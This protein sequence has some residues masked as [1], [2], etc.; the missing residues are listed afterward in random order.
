MF[1]IQIRSPA[2]LGDKTGS[3]FD[4]SWK[5]L[6]DAI[7]MI[8]SG[9]SSELSFEVL[10]RTV[11]SVVLRKQGEQ[12]YERIH[13]AIDRKLRSVKTSSLNVKSTS[14]LDDIL[15]AWNVQRESL[16]VI[17]DV[18]MYLD[19]VYCKESRK[20]FVYDMGIDLFHNII[21]KS[22]KD[23]LYGLIMGQINNA[24]QSIADVDFQQLK[25]LVEMMETV[26]NTS[27]TYFLAEFEPFLL[28]ETQAFY[29]RVAEE[30]EGELFTYPSTVETLLTKE[31]EIDA[32]FL[33]DSVRLKI[34]KE[35]RGAL[36]SENIQFVGM[37]VLPSILDS[38]R[39]TELKLLFELCDNSNDRKKIW[40]HLSQ[41]IT[42]EGLNIN[43]DLTLKKKSQVAVRW[44]AEVI[45]LNEK[46]EGFFNTLPTSEPNGLKYINEATSAF[47]NQNGKTSAEYL[48]IYIDSMLRLPSE[49]GDMTK[50]RLGKSVKVFRLLRQK[51]VFEKLYHQQLSKRLLQQRSSLESEKNF[52]A[53][54]EEEAGAMFALK[55]DGM[56]RDLLLSQSNNQKFR[57]SYNVPFEFEM[58]VLTSTCWPFQQTSS[59]KEVALPPA[60]EKLKLD[61]ENYYLKAYSGRALKWAYHLG[62]IEIGFQFSK[63]YHIITMPVF[64]AI[65]LMLFEDYDELNMQEIFD[66]THIP[67]QELMRNLLTIAVAPKTR[68]LKKQ[69]L[70]KRILPTDRFRLNYSFSAPTTKVK[71]LAILYKGDFDGQFNPRSSDSLQDL[72]KERI[73]CVEACIV[74]ALKFAT[75][76]YHDPLYQKVRENLANRFEVSSTM[77]QKSLDKLLEREYVQRDPDECTLYHYLP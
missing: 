64:A 50:D 33:G 36:I 23:Q 73:R 65:I 5:I 56:F 46:Y 2:G 20:P 29:S 1:K 48:A 67:E 4:A 21:M 53:I 70:S 13:D 31:Q 40:K 30:Y 42:K 62:S 69:P 14:L 52:L 66:L 72:A 9:R 11:Y 26:A 22:S 63:S 10:F 51:D 41:C 8:F 77:F 43:E 49:E 24:R 68:L 60:L 58:S 38:N 47:L 12:L 19:K 15:H 3:T 34:S 39:F 75:K 71:V 25:Y 44:I 18:T 32:K 45:K 54:M 27:D 61:Y 28:R 74:R 55:P 59:E 17:S 7:E 76:M 35:I 6:E 16:R 57:Q 37:Q